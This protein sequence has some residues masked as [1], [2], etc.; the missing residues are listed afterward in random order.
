MDIKAAIE[1]L[2]D[3]LEIAAEKYNEARE[4]LG[5]T[6]YKIR[7]NKKKLKKAV[8]SLEWAQHLLNMRARG[9][10]KN[11]GR[12]SYFEMIFSTQNFPQF[13]EKMDMMSEIGNQDSRTIDYVRV[14][15][16]E[17]EQRKAQLLDERSERKAIKRE[18]A[19]NKK[20]IERK[21]VERKRLY[22]SAKDQ[23]SALEREEAERQSELRREALRNLERSKRKAREGGG[24]YFRASST[25][26]AH[27][28]VVSIALSYLGA[29]YVWGGSSPSGF[30]CSGFV[31]Y[32]YAQVGISLPHSSSAQ[33]GSGG[34]VNRDSLEPGDLVFFGSPI[35]HVGIYIGNDSFVHAPHSGD[36]VKISSLSSRSN[37]SGACR[38]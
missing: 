4:K 7:I 27:G 5:E 11:E 24:N 6:N 36:V 10:Y 35:H 12:M 34:Y 13:I 23:L 33:Y 30:D 38:P 20:H 9:I 25:A 19:S 14:I 22:E 16:G 18:M 17:I 21:L 37:Y 31:M 1:K 15:K 3:K 8:R 28:G 32:V 2:D 29:P 26:P